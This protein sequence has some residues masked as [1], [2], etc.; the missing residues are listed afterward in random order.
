MKDKKSVKP[1]TDKHSPNDKRS[2]VKNENNV[3]HKKDLINRI[4]QKESSQS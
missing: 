1:K 4:N 2:I 3:A